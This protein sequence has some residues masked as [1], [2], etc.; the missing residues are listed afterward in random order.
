[1]SR[2][3]ICTPTEPVVETKA[4]RLRGCIVDGTCIF[5][6]V[7]YAEARRFMQPEPVSPW[8]GI[9]DALDYG[10]VCPLLE[11]ESP[12]GDTLIPHRFWPKSEDCLSLN[13]WT[14]SLDGRA[15]KPVMVW[16][17]GGG[18]S[19]GSSIEMV[20]Y[21]G[22]NLSKYGDVVVVT[23]NH[24]L[25][26][27][28]YCDLSAYGDKYFNSANAGQADLVEALK[29]V[30]D[31]IAA[32]GGD[33]DNVTL[34]GQS[35]GAAKINCLLQTPAAEG[36]FH[37]AILMSGVGGR[38]RGSFPPQDGEGNIAEAIMDELGAKSAEA[39]EK[40][41]LEE[42]CAASRAALGKLEKKGVRIWWAPK[43]NGWYLGDPYDVG[44][45]D[46][47]KRVPVMVGS[48]ICEW[49]F[50]PA[51]A[52]KN[53]MSPAERKRLLD[54]YF[55]TD[56]AELIALFREAY[57]DKNEL[58]LM[59]LSNRLGTLEYASEKAAQSLAPVYNYLFAF[60]F[61]YDGG[62]PAWHCSDIPFVFRNTDKVPICNQPGVSDGLEEA[63]CGAFTA[64]ARYGDPNH[65]GMDKWP[66]YTADRPATMYFDR[67]CEASF[68]DI[69]L[70]E[71]HDKIA[72]KG[73]FF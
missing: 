26:I 69:R 33:P 4:G 1:M 57:P 30:R 32:F 37:K 22:E 39:L 61:P 60:T 45:T 6:G 20:A 10:Y 40:A 53:E 68:K 58:D 67:S 44:F 42:L 59:A 48:V 54:G 21:D 49:G 47:A 3:F 17:H 73:M 55:K 23:V 56:S 25:N 24:R 13:I 9:K 2:T 41:G 52:G 51:P 63:V 70:M 38:R 5:R 64:F 28:G 18:F 7:K 71:L 11:P 14:Q 62:K 65:K 19:T 50:M 36:L 29:W 27:F 31:N 16:I 43:A 8:D 34:F 66:A 72:P 46:F 12:F 35:G 15:K